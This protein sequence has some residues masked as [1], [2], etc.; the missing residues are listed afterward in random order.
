MFTFNYMKRSLKCF[1][2]VGVYSNYLPVNMYDPPANINHRDFYPG[3]K[4][5]V[6]WQELLNEWIEDWAYSLMGYM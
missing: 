5:A 4:I 3:W 6:D 2:K 1:A